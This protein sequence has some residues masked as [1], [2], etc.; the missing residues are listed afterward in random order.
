MDDFFYIGV[1]APSFI[2]TN[3]YCLTVSSSSN[4]SMKSLLLF[5]DDL[6]D[7]YTPVVS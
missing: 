4:R 5:P 3:I 6:D 1:R 2:H 7:S